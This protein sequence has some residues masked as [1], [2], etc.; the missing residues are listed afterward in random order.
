M[1]V[2]FMLCSTYGSSSSAVICFRTDLDP[3]VQRISNWIYVPHTLLRRST[4]NLS[5]FVQHG[6]HDG[7]LPVA[8]L[9]AL[10]L[11]AVDHMCMAPVLSFI[12][13]NPAP[14]LHSRPQP[15]RLYSPTAT[16]LICANSHREDMSSESSC[17]RPA[18]GT[19][20]LS[21]TSSRSGS[22]DGGEEKEETCVD[23]PWVRPRTGAIHVDAYLREPLLAVHPGDCEV[24]YRSF[25]ELRYGR[26]EATLPGVLG[27]CIFGQAGVRV[28]PAKARLYAFV[29]ILPSSHIPEF[30]HE[31]HP[32]AL[33]PLVPFDAD[34]HLSAAFRQA[35]FFHTLLGYSFTGQTTRGSALWL[36]FLE[37]AEVAGS[38][39]SISRASRNSSHRVSINL[40]TLEGGNVLKPP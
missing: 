25:I 22:P 37:T 28:L 12:V 18:R 5:D 31:R 38:I 3:K 23:L 7:P 24:I 33:P 35:V 11:V 4:G 21:W 30:A 13:H 26:Y 32:H 8:K 40:A 15:S 29:S 9:S 34:K 6:K 19:S 17:P 1:A 2:N 20:S 36:P 14:K 39:Q 10:V 27:A 16:T